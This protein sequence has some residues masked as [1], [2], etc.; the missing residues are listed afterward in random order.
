VEADPDHG[1][2]LMHHYGHG[3]QGVT[4]SWATA[5]EVADRLAE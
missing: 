2:R 1:T 3:R 5:A 4:L